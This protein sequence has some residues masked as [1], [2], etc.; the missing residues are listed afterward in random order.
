MRLIYGVMLLAPCAKHAL[1]TDMGPEQ[2]KKLAGGVLEIEANTLLDARR[3]LDG[4]FISA[5]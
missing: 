2:V 4:G 5:V 3:K 1:H